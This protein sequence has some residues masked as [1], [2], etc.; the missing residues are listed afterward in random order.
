MEITIKI[1]TIKSPSGWFGQVTIDTVTIQTPTV[2]SEE[3]AKL[4]LK[5]II[6]REID[7]FLGD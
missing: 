7:A 4:L 5:Q 3:K 6:H 2:R 1:K